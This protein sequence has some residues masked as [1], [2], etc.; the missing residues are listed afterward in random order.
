MT[1]DNDTGHVV[2]S[3]PVLVRK[4]YLDCTDR[5]VTVHTSL[6]LTRSKYISVVYVNGK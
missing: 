5:T 2:G 4:S 3:N 1:D 6:L